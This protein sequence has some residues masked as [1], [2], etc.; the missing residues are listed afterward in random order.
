M[1]NFTNAKL[2]SSNLKSAQLSFSNFTGADLSYANLT[3]A[4]LYG[5]DL[6]NAILN[7]TILVRVDLRNAKYK[8]SD[9][10][11]CKKISGLKITEDR[12]FT[13]EMLVL[14]KAGAK[15]Y[16]DVDRDGDNSVEVTYEYLYKNDVF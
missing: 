4:N 7:N 12:N 9:L 2:I 16:G 15:I 13:D 11:K 10:I 14:A 3:D 8:I 6:S 5:S 1:I